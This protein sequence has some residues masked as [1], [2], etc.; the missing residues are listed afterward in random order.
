MTKRPLQSTK[1]SGKG[2]VQCAD[3]TLME[4]HQRGELDVHEHDDE[5]DDNDTDEEPDPYAHSDVGNEPVDASY[6]PDAAVGRFANH[7]RRLLKYERAQRALQLR[8]AGMTYAAIAREL[9]YAS[10][11]T[12]SNIVRRH[13]QL[14][15]REDAMALRSLNYD[16][17]NEMLSRA[18]M[19]ALGGYTKEDG[20]IA[21]PDAQ[22]MQRAQSLINDMNALMGANAATESNVNMNVSG[23]VVTVEWDEEQ[24]IAAMRRAANA[25]IEEAGVVIPEITAGPER[26]KATKAER[27]ELGIIDAEV[28]E[29]TPGYERTEAGEIIPPARTRVKAPRRKPQN[30]EHVPIEDMAGGAAIKD[31]RDL[32]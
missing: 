24:Y 23:A 19:Y 8:M 22:W 4:L 25:H 5:E 30:E 14:E 13:T 6:P 9:G 7:T 3:V 18:W 20:T 26:Y 17:L 2:S 31:I 27:D 32:L 12:V 21:K 28:V 10:A 15:Q 16:R 1:A 11:N 29:D